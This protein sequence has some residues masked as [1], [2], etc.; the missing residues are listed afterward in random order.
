[1]ARRAEE[2]TGGLCRRERVH[3]SPDFPIV[4]FFTLVTGPRRSLSHDLSDTR[5]YGSNQELLAL[6]TRPRGTDG[7]IW[8]RKTAILEKP[9]WEGSGCK[10][11]GK[12]EK[13]GEEGSRRRKGLRV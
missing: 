13:G 2:K 4:F 1:M 8:P 5:V 10:G 12:E 9:R 3:R 6:T 7:S 11:G